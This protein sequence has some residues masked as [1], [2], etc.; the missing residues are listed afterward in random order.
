MEYLVRYGEKWQHFF[1][2]SQYGLCV[3]QY[4]SGRFSNFEVL[5]PEAC[6]DFCAISIDD[7]IHIVCQDA[8]GNIV[9][10]CLLNGS[11]QR[12]VLMENK[13][14][15]PY[16][17]YFSLVPSGRFLNLF[18]VISYQ[19]K[20]MLVHQ[21]IGVSDRPPTVVDRISGNVPMFIAEN[22]RGTD[23]SVYY[24]NEAGINGRRVFRWS[25]KEFSRFM[26]ICAE[27]RLVCAVMAEP[28]GCTRYGAFQRVCDV[29]NLVYFE[30]KEDGSL[31]E[32]VTVNL[33]SPRD[34]LPVFWQGK[35]KLYLFWRESGS[36]MSSHSTDGGK[37]WSKPARYM[38]G[39][40]V[41]P[42]LYHLYS[43][44]KSQ[45]LYGYEKDREI[46]FYADAGILDEPITKAEKTFRP[47]GYEVEE[48]AWETMARET[49]NEVG[50]AVFLQLKD[51]FLKLK[52]QFFT[53]HRRVT[54]LSQ[55]VDMIEED[56]KTQNL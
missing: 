49:P 35:D 33:D 18:Y 54:E 23:I 30:E 53:L 28:D 46:V 38:K 45:L 17:K 51:D 42:V 21:I 47:A 56:E 36:V 9:Y 13:S 5:L 15:R 6:E 50:D 32:S 24:K 2:K 48:F 31:T 52:E 10:L 12:S 37:K 29:E 16:P 39:T 34:G 19:E 55:R 20:Q 7:S 26:P 14:V 11:W 8:K 40:S 22:A 3:R 25:K 27:E 4:E 1:I 44:G 41:S 43:R